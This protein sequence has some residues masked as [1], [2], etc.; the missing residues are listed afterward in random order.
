MA[1]A[2]LRTTTGTQDFTVSGAGT[3]GGYILIL[4]Y[5]TALG[6]VELF[7]STSIGWTDGTND[8]CMY[9]RHDDNITP[10]ANR[11][12]LD[13]ALVGALFGPGSN[14]PDITITH[15]SFITDG[16]RISVDSTN[17]RAVQ[18]TVAMFPSANFSLVN[19]Y[20][21]ESTG[22]TDITTVG[23]TSLVVLGM[24]IAKAGITTGTFAGPQMAIG[25]SDGTNQHSN[26]IRSSSGSA[27]ANITT[28]L[29]TAN[30][31]D[32][33]DSNSFDNA[34]NFNNFDG[35][36]YDL[37]NSVNAQD[38]S[39][40]SIAS[41]SLG[42]HIQQFQTP[43]TPTVQTYSGMTFAPG[44]I[45]CLFS[46]VATS[47]TFTNS[48]DQGAWGYGV[49]DGVTEGSACIS[50][51][52][53]ANPSNTQSLADSRV[54]SV[55]D[56]SSSATLIEGTVDS[57]AADEVNIDFTKVT[58]TGRYGVLISFEAVMGASGGGLTTLATMGVGR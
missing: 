34:S 25:V 40:L 41:V 28:G 21:A 58:G 8:A 4:S 44:F 11:Y 31:V 55:I 48:G 33:T 37:V 27:G 39:A 42:V 51:E 7:A 57:F 54:I 46:N 35:S 5:A 47:N 23:Q 50:I 22:T 19:S 30:A 15:G 26:A 20:H 16:I 24:A 9:I 3:M 10:M 2:A 43:T 17:A 36:G 49:S 14:T 18:A 6:T 1:R 45:L 53:G 38:V 56:P 52:D 29:S 13:D 32:T 12:M